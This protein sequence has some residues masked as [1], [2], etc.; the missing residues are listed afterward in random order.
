MDPASWPLW[1]IV[2]GFCVAAGA[3]AVVGTKLAHV[4]EELA[5]ITGLGQA[6]FGIVFLGGTTSLSGMVT[7][8]TAAVDGHPTLSVSNA[9]GGIAAQTVFLAIADAVYP[10]ANLEHA[11]ASPAN[12]MQGALLV[13]LLALPILAMAAPELSLLGVH[14][15]TVMIVVGF[16]FGLS[17]IRSTRTSPMWEARR[18]TDTAPEEEVAP[19]GGR[20]LL[21]AWSVYGV[22]AVTIGFAG[23]AIA[24]TGSAIAA[25]TG[26]GESVVGTFLTAVSTSLPELVTAIAAVRRGALTLAVGD[27]LGG[28]CFDLLLLAAADVAYRS[29][30]IYAAVG[31]AE[32]FV[33]ALSILLAGVLLLGLLRR[34]RHGP[35]NIG[36]ESV[37]VIVLYVAG[38]VYVIAAR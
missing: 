9:I 15:I 11:A 20:R 24:Q 18:T 27:I 6:M 32:L 25:R 36:F 4:A 5:K 28:N 31:G 2:V 29:G 37:L 33:M 19:E 12:L 10:K 8:I 30:A 21:R 34:E 35:A 3:I 7:S 38:A 14:P 17:L 26:L 1:A 22:L 23:Y 16:V 13:T